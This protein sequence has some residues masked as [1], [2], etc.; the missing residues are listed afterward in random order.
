MGLTRL[1]DGV[2]LEKVEGRGMSMMTPRSLAG[3]AAG[4]VGLFL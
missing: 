4:V 1:G 3:V 2:N